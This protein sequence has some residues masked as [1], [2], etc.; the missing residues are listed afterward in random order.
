MAATCDALAFRCSRRA[1]RLADGGQLWVAISGGPGAGK[2]TIAAAVAE[3]CLSLYGVEAVV[4]PMDGF[5]YSKAQLAA[6]DPHSAAPVLQTPTAAS[7]LPR[8]G[9]PHTFD[10]ELFAAELARARLSKTH[11]FP[12]YSR[13]LSDPV[14]GGAKLEQKHRIVLVEG[15]YLL[16][17]GL[18]D[19]ADASVA[20]E[21]KRWAAVQAMF[22]D[23][24]FVQPAGGVAEQRRRLVER[25]LETWTPEKTVR[26]T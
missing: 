23:T 8:R 12:T 7:Y 14:P 5:H 13:E 4:V 17:G 1:A 19:D 6:L 11:A 10:A 2:S 26:A 16:L 3:R 25:H 9:A 21:A 24:W 15:N 22:D 18:A 20:K